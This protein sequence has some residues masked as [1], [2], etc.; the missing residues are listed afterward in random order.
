MEWNNGSYYFGEYVAG[1]RHGVGMYKYPENETYFG[2]LKTQKFDGN[3]FYYM[4]NKG[5]AYLGSWKDDKKDG[6]TFIFFRHEIYTD[7]FSVFPG[8]IT[9]PQEEFTETLHCFFKFTAGAAFPDFYC[10]NAAQNSHNGNDD[11]HF[12]Q[13]K[14]TFT[15]MEHWAWSQKGQ[16]FST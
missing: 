3:G 13:R 1:D 10:C 4:A 7:I 9:A 8:G 11:S 14:E 15:A 16:F 12:H 6:N 2:D 5:K